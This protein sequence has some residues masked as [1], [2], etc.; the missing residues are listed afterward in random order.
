MSTSIRREE[1]STLGDF[2]LTSFVRDQSA[3]LVRYPKLNSDYLKDFVSKLDFIKQLES[4][5]VLTEAQKEITASLHQEA[6][7]L[8]DELSFVRTYL[9]DAKLNTTTVTDLKADL[10]S[11]NIEGAVKKIEDLKQYVDTNKTILVEQGM[12][13]SFIDALVAHKTSLTQKN[14]A[15]NEFMNNR[16]QL[17][18]KNGSHYDELYECIKE[19]NKKGKLVFKN[20]ITADEYT[21][22]NNIARMRVTRQTPKKQ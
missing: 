13:S 7:T 21:L 15:Q 18:D 10:H 14:N 16:K 1:Y 5:L 11:H 20:T 19:I 22:K 2:L 6:T 17:T 9:Q 3:I 4:S 8:Y 12:Q